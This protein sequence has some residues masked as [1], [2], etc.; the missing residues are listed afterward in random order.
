[1]AILDVG[2][3]DKAVLADTFRLFELSLIA[4]LHVW[5][6]ESGCAQSMKSRPVMADTAPHCMLAAFI[7][8]WPGG[9]CNA[10]SLC[11]MCYVELLCQFGLHWLIAGTFQT[12][13]NYP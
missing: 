11:V 2:G 1:M 13:V 5:V 10:I 4:G 7:Q 3:D 6:C 9:P 8:L 12:F